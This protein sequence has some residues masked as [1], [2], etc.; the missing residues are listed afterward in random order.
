MDDTLWIANSKNE[1]KLITDM[2]SSFYHMAD[3]QINPIKSILVSNTSSTNELSF[4]ASS[5]KPIL[6]SQLFKFLEYWFILN[7]S[8]FKQSQIIQ[9]EATQLINITSTKKITGKQAVYIINTII[10]PTIEYRL[11]NIILSQSTCN[12]ILSKYLIVVKHKSN[13]SRSFPNSSILNPYMYNIH[14]IWDIQL[15]HHITNF[16]QWINDPNILGI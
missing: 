9:D 11:H 13:L 7:E 12:N 15:Q 16:Q 14:D 2:A 5:I 10:I 6:A 4:F 8:M 1:L 3:T